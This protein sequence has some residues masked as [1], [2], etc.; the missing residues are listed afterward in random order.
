MFSVSEEEYII[1]FKRL[2]GASRVSF[3]F[4]KVQNLFRE[5]CYYMRTDRTT[6]RMYAGIDIPCNFKLCVYVFMR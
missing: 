3:A 6:Y 1:I 2:F 5:I 4:A